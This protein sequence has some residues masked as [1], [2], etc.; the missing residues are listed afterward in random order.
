MRK[1][2]CT[3]LIS[4]VLSVF[5]FSVSLHGISFADGHGMGKE[6]YMQCSSCHNAQQRNLFGK[7]EAAL[8]KRFQYFQSG[9][10][11]SGAAKKMKDLFAK[12]SDKEQASLAKY[13]HTM[14]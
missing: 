8:L 11:T 12:M 7:N 4:S 3:V 5:F 2:F 14:K 9:N 1:T 6:L 10:F 13:I